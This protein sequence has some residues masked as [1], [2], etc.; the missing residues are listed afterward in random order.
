MQPLPRSGRGT[1]LSLLGIGLL[2]LLGVVA[3]ASRSGSRRHGRAPLRAIGYVNYAVTVFLILFVLMIPVAVYAFLLRLRERSTATPQ[4]LQGAPLRLAACAG[5]AL[6][7]DRVRLVLLP[8]PASAS[9]AAPQSLPPAQHEG[10]PRSR[11]RCTRAPTPSSSGTSS[12]SRSSCSRGIGAFGYYRW[13]T[14]KPAA[15]AARRRT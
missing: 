5:S 8:Q 3:F 11:P 4:E 10:S 2:V 6:V 7:R 15:A 14:R 12:G 13:K 1:R 9:P